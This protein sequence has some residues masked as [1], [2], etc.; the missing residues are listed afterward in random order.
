MCPGPTLAR[1]DWGQ[2]SASNAKRWAPNGTDAAIVQELLRSRA[3]SGKTLLRASFSRSS[4]MYPCSLIGKT[5]EESVFFNTTRRARAG[6]KILQERD[7]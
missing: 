7:R 4:R 2:S 1:E 5:S 3:R 6:L